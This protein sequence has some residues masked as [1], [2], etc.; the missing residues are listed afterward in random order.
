MTS[1]FS[2][3]DLGLAVVS[4]GLVVYLAGTF[5]LSGVSITVELD[6]S[7]V[8]TMS[9]D[10]STVSTMSTETSTDCIYFKFMATP[11]LQS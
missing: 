7:T 1:M 8:S 3:L 9:T 6:S 11:C 2:Y 5:Q 10:R 4:A